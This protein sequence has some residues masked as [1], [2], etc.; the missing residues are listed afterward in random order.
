M[1]MTDIEKHLQMLGVWKKVPG[2]DVA[3]RLHLFLAVAHQPG[4]STEF[5]AKQLG[6][7]P[8]I[9]KRLLLEIGDEREVGQTGIGLIQTNDNHHSLTVKGTAVIAAMQNQE[10]TA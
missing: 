4:Q 3:G 1:T 7:M 5:Y 8:G 9:T 2:A 10:K 6:M